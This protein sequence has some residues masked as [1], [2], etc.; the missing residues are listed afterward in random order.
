MIDRVWT[1]DSEIS[2]LQRLNTSLMHKCAYYR[3]KYLQVVA[4]INNPNAQKGGNGD[5]N[6]EKVCDTGIKKARRR[7]GSNK[8]V[9]LYG[10]ESN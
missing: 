8:G 9:V 7:C 1:K 10:R 6:D 2:M 4:E 3:R 5:G